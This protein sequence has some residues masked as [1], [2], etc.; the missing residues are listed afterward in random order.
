VPPG[1]RAPFVLVF[2]E[3]PEGLDAFRLEVTLEAVTPEGTKQ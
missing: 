1:G 2:Q 3:Y